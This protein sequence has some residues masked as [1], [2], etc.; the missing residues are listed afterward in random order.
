MVCNKKF[1]YIDRRITYA[2]Y[3]QLAKKLLLIRDFQ[4]N[5]GTFLVLQKTNLVADRCTR[6]RHV[7]N[8]FFLSEHKISCL[9]IFDEKKITININNLKSYTVNMW[10]GNIKYS[11]QFIIIR[12][13]PTIRNGFH[14]FVIVNMFVGWFFLGIFVMNKFK[15]N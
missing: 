11:K 5:F 9:F 3:V 15:T 1:V 8:I 13:V 10:M 2:D 7:I 6:H 4:I 12:Y 14:R